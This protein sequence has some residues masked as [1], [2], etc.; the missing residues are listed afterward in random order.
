MTKLKQLLLPL[1]CLS[2]F[3]LSCDN[4]NQ[5]SSEEEETP[6]NMGVTPVP[7]PDLD[8]PGFTFPTDSAVINE[9]V[10][11]QNLEE[12]YRHSWGIWAGL[13]T[14]TSQSIGGQNLLVFETWQTP[15]EITD[16]INGN[17]TPRD[18]RANLNKPN[19]FK[20]AAR[21][22]EE[23]HPDFEVAESVSY[24]PKAANF[25]LENKLF[26]AKTLAKY[27]YEGRT[28]IPTFPSNAITLKPVFKVITKE[29]LDANGLYTLPTWPGPISRE[30]GFPEKDWN[31]CVYV[32]LNNN[33]H[34][35]GSIDT[36]CEGP[37]AATTYNLTDFIHYALNEEDAAY[38]N[39]EFSLNAK[40]GDYAI[41]VA[42]HTTTREI[43]RWAWQTFWWTANPEQ[44]NAPSSSEIADLRPMEFLQGAAKHYAMAVAYNMVAPAQ[45]LTGGKSVGS[46]NIAFNPY[47]EAKFGPPVFTGSNSYVIDRGVKVS[48]AAG[49]RTNC[50]SCH[51]Y[52]AYDAYD[53][54]NGTPY[55]GDAYV[56]LEDPIFDGKLK[57][58]FAWSIADNLD[59][60]G[61]A[62]FIASH[63]KPSN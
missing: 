29:K 1:F 39:N 25:A 2:F 57:L 60:T 35:D 33:S 38:F 21:F 48:T 27:Q 16:E 54:S 9:W 4:I 12:M 40:A 28:E 3:C 13:T 20:H 42:M 34:G 62:A 53:P 30:I 10:A 37:S 59:T 23:E 24:N 41:L 43:T 32:D 17:P 49:V 55:S 6:T 8:I 63:P 45:P 46:P 5:S 47:L 52:A 58:D 19:Q 50:M 44:P 18:G 51:I 14:P 22:A 15:K 7:F 36:G 61:L 56:S 11:T 26:L 31:A